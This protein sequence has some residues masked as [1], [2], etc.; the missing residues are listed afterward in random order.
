MAVIPA[1]ILLDETKCYACFGMTLAD[2]LKLGL[3]SRIY[4]AE[5]SANVP[6]STVTLTE[7]FICNVD[8]G[9]APIG[10][11]NWTAYGTTPTIRTRVQTGRFGTIMLQTAATATSTA[12]VGSKFDGNSG[13]GIVSVSVVPWSYTWVFRFNEL[14]DVFHRIG[15]IGVLPSLATTTQEYN[16]FYLR[17]RA[18]TD[19]GQF[20][21]VN[22]FAAAGPETAVPSSI[23]AD[24]EWHTLK[25]RSTTSGVCLYSLDGE[26]EI[27]ISENF[28]GTPRNVV[29]L[30]GTEVN[31]LK[32]VYLDKIVMQLPN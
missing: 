19:A 32:Q 28:L 2:L 14:T 25:I 23:P 29:A 22:R 26:T 9:A 4:D 8:S 15:L 31:T 6:S 3:L 20:M 11:M 30:A 13:S 24:T 10:E 5:V 27:A 7:H 16:G 18:S 21:F 1:S 17:Y 12:G